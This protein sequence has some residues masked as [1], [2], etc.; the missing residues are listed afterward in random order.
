MATP[1]QVSYDVDIFDFDT[2]SVYSPKIA[3]L[4]SVMIDHKLLIRECRLRY[5]RSGLFV[6]WPSRKITD[7]Q[8]IRYIEILDTPLRVAVEHAAVAAY[9]AS[10]AQ[11]PAAA[12]LEAEGIN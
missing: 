3:A 11:D 8:F 10:L 4:F 1:P 9:E 7:D 6:A 5:G 2:S 12:A